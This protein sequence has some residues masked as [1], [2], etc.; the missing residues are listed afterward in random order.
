MQQV[1]AILKRFRGSA[2]ARE[3]LFAPLKTW[4]ENKGFKFDGLDLIVP[5]MTVGNSP[6]RYSR[7]RYGYHYDVPAAE[8]TAYEDAQKAKRKYERY[9]APARARYAAM[10][11]AQRARED[12][13]LARKVVRV[14]EK[15]RRASMTHDQRKLAEALDRQG[16]RLKLELLNPTVNMPMVRKAATAMSNRLETAVGTTDAT[17]INDLLGDLHTHLPPTHP[18]RPLVDR[19]LALNMN[20]SVM[21]AP[22]GAIKAYGEYRASSNGYQT[23]LLN[24]ER[25]EDIRASGGDPA[26]GFIHTVLHEAVHPATV[27]ELK[28]NAPLR[29]AMVSIMRQ[30]RRAAAEQGVSLKYG[31]KEFYAIRDNDVFEFVAEAFTNDL[32]QE[33]MRQIAITPQRSVWS[34]IV[35]LVRKLLGMDPKAENVLELVL[36]TADALFTGRVAST[37]GSTAV[38]VYAIEDLSARTAVR[39]VTD[40][41][42][43]GVRAANDMRHRGAKR[44]TEDVPQCAAAHDGALR[45]FYAKS[46]GGVRGGLANYMRAFFHRNSEVSR[47]MES[48]DALSRRWTALNEESS[49]ASLEASRIM[50]EAT[51][52]GMHPDRGFTHKDN[53][54]LTTVSSNSTMPSCRSASMSARAWRKMYA[55]LQTYYRETLERRR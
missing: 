5:D 27:E 2:T 52:F 18:L 22:P 50:S 10:S 32:F 48:A 41:I 53:K 13:N 14:T 7:E 38:E 36:S 30:M 16:T 11:P 37:A 24:R 6:L 33:Q 23:I 55:D 15:E 20:V 12:Y 26:M 46:F 54:H 42:T 4:F 45:D 29:A 19:L 35:E 39:E 25:F 34:H 3:Y 21:W 1:R 17:R 51:Q 31:N 49:E 47:L 28:T 40:R 43:Q 44:I 9:L 8:R